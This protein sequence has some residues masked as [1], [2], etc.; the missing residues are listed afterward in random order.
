MRLLVAQRDEECENHAQ[1]GKS[2]VL[3][4]AWLVG[5]SAAAVTLCAPANATSEREAEREAP[6]TA[7]ST[8]A[9]SLFDDGVRLM[10]EG[11]YADA[12][13]KLAESHRLDP[14]SGTIYNLAICHEKEGKLASAYVAYDEALAASARDGHGDREVIARGRLDALRPRLARVVLRVDASVAGLEV[15]LDGTP[16]HREAIGL[17]IP[18]DRGSHLVEASAPGYVASSR[19]FVVV[20]DG[21]VVEVRVPSLL[22]AST[23]SAATSST[24]GPT[25]DGSGLKAVGFVLGGVAIAALAAGTL[26]AVLAIDRHAESDQECP[27][28]RCSEVGAQAESAANRFA[29]GANIG[30]GTGLVAGA[31]G[32]YL[33]FKSGPAAPRT[34]V[35]LS[36]QAAGATGA[37][38][39]G[40]FE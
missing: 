12:C 35:T 11:R 28:G 37:F 3:R 26:C 13:P 15:R 8:V 33:L 27:G 32:G 24:S 40:R 18:A 39:V 10:G 21:K 6:A 7:G 34:Q 2:S 9:Q 4:A 16:V 23:P 38:L 19:A 5:V 22:R 25:S 20:A 30:I 1:M 29:W 36:P 31:V 14:A 17:P